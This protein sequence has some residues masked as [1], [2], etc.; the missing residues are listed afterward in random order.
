MNFKQ[1]LIRRIERHK[2]RYNDL[3]KISE[4]F[5]GLKFD[6]S[7]LAYNS[8]AAKTFGIIYECEEILKEYIKYESVDSLK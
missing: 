3:V 6:V 7:Y 4:S 8:E 2:E 5:T 1:N